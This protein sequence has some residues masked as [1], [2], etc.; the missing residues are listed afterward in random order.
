VL[1][2]ECP[3]LHDPQLW[4]HSCFDDSGASGNREDKQCGMFCGFTIAVVST[5]CY[6]QFKSQR[7]R[8]ARLPVDHADV[9]QLTALTTFWV[10]MDCGVN[11]WM[12]LGL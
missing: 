1:L 9:L 6:L 3:L 12:M 5:S 2:V 11:D 7:L 10:Q 4:A 8:E